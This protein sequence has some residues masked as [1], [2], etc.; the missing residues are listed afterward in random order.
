MATRRRYPLASRTLLKFYHSLYWPT[1]LFVK[2]EINR[3]IGLCHSFLHLYNSDAM[4]PSVHLLCSVFFTVHSS[5]HRYPESGLGGWGT[6]CQAPKCLPDPKF[7]Y[8]V[9]NRTDKSWMM[10]YAPKPPPPNIFLWTAAVDTVKHGFRLLFI[11]S[12][13]E[14]LKLRCTVL[15]RKKTESRRHKAE[16][17]RCNTGQYCYQLS[18]TYLHR[19]VH[20][21]RQTDGQT[22]RIT[23]KMT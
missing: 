20:T 15:Q 12:S 9:Y 2:R 18:L 6:G 7:W 3:P 5:I 8:L 1:V 17:Q 10:G 22:D 19:H 13:L 21:D 23:N 11:E 14:A 4:V 16:H